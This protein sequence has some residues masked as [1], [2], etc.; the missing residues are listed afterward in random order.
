MM[1]KEAALACG[2]DDEGLEELS[3]SETL[4]VLETLTLVFTALRLRVLV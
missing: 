3:Q 2:R 1:G 4:Y